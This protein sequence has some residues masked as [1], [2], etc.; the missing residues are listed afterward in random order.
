MYIINK[1]VPCLIKYIKEGKK[2]SL[3]QQLSAWKFK[4]SEIKRFLDFVNK[5]YK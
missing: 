2:K 3:I 1:I 5:H 4:W